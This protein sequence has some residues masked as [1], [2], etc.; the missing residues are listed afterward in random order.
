MNK[1]NII[2]N[3]ISTTLPSI[4]GKNIFFHTWWSPRLKTWWKLVFLRIIY[5]VTEKL[6]LSV[7]DIEYKQNEKPNTIII[8]SVLRTFSTL[9]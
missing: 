3:K 7:M 5:S 6:H 4:V 9:F 2:K 1:N 8:F